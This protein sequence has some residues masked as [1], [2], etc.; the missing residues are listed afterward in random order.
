MQSIG[1]VCV[2][3]IDNGQG[4]S[5]VST[6]QVVAVKLCFVST[7]NF[8]LLFVVVVIVFL[9]H[10]LLPFL[11]FLSIMNFCVYP[12]TPIVGDATNVSQGG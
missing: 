9:S 12:D 10:F 7:Y 4:F 1:S 8:N 6:V 5:E 11:S 2:E 3:V